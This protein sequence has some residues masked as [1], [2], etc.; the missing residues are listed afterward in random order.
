MEANHTATKEST[1]SDNP[2]IEVT[3]FGETRL[4]QVY[5]FP[6]ADR[7]TSLE[8]DVV[9]KFPTGSKLHRS[10]ITLC[11]RHQERAGKIYSCHGKTAAVVNGEEYVADYTLYT[12]NSN[13]GRIVG[14]YENAQSPV[15][16]KWGGA[17]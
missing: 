5:I 1:V 4:V 2:V 12:H 13:R 17:Y 7:I 10:P 3:L 15:I 11:K 6:G 14:W 9:G 16:A 8:L